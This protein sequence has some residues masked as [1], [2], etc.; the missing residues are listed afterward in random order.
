MGIFRPLFD[1][2]EFDCTADV[3]FDNSEDEESSSGDANVLGTWAFEA[4]DPPLNIPEIVCMKVFFPF[5]PPL[6]LDEGLI[7]DLFP[8][9]IEDEEVVEWVEW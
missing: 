1:P 2:T 8:P 5:R 3:S 7:L 4:V 9:D 6:V